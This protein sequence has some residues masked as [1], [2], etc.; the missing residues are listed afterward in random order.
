MQLLMEK[1]FA[2]GSSST[3]KLGQETRGW[4]HVY[5]GPAAAPG[6]SYR[7]KG[8]ADVWLEDEWEPTASERRGKQ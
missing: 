2:P 3:G 1:A 4:G 8:G 7:Q 6:I 5:L